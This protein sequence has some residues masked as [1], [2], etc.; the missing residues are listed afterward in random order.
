MFERL[1]L[2][3]IAPFCVLFLAVAGVGKATTITTTRAEVGQMAALWETDTISISALA[4]SQYPAYTSNWQYIF[5][6]SSISADG[7]IH[8]DMGVDSSGSGSSGNNIGESPII[9]EVINASSSQLSHLTSLSGHQAIFRGIFRFY[10]EHAGERHF[11]LHPTTQLQTWNGSAF[12]LDADYHSTVTNVADGATHASSTY[13]NLLNGSETMMATIAANNVNVTFSYPSPSV[14][15]IEYDGVVVS[16]LTSDA[17]SSYIVFRPNLVPNTTVRCR[18]IANTN[19]AAVA[20]GLGTGQPLTVNALTRTDMAAVADQISGLGPGDS[21]TFGRPVEFITLDLA[22]L[23]AIAVTLAPSGITSTQATLNGSVDPNGVTTTAYFQYGTSTNYGNTT[24]FQSVGSSTDAVG[25]SNQL[26]GL[27]MN[28]TYHYRTVATNSR[29]TAYGEDRT[30]TTSQT[31]VPTIT[32]Q[33]ASDVFQTTATLHGLV[34]PNGFTT[35]VQF[36]Y[37]K[38]TNYGTTTPIQSIGNGNGDVAVSANLTGLQQSQVYHFRV[39]ATNANGTRLGPDQTLNT[40]PRT[41]IVVTS[42]ATDVAMDSATL[43]GV[44][45]PGALSTTYHFE[46]GTGTTYGTSTPNQSAGSGSIDVAVST[47]LVA[48]LQPNTTYHFRLVATNSKGTAD[49]ADQV[50]TTIPLPPAATTSAATAV[51]NATA[52]LNGSVNPNGVAGTAQFEYGTTASYGNTTTAQSIS[53]SNNPTAVSQGIGGLTASTT[54]HFRVVA[55]T[56]G[57]TTFGADQM[58][59]TASSAPPT[60]STSPASVYGPSTVTFN[61]TV[62]ANAAPTTFYFEYGTTTVYGLTTP[63][64]QIGAPNAPMTFSA[65]VA[66]LAYDTVYH[67]RAVA[68]NSTGT[69]Y[70]SDQMF[71]TH[72]NPF[73]Q[74]T[75]YQFNDVGTSSGTSSAGDS[76]YF[77]VIFSNFT[78]VGVSANSNAS[79]RFSFTNQPLGATNGSDVFTGG[80]DLGKYYEFTVTPFSGWTIN[81]KTITFTLQRSGTGIRQYSVRS[82]VDNFATNL[83]ASINPANAD[84]MV[85]NTPHLN[86]FQVSDATTSAE[87]GTTITLDSRFYAIPGPITFR[88]YGYNAEGSVGTFSVDNVAIIGSSEGA[89][90][91]VVKPD[92]ASSITATTAALHT[93]VNPSNDETTVYFVYGPTTDY[94][95]VTPSVF[96]SGGTSDTAILQQIT[97]LKSYT[98]YHYKV[99]SVNSIGVTTGPDQTFTTASG[100]RDGDGVPDDWEVLNGLNPDDPSDALLDAD[101]DGFTNLQEYSAG[102][103]PQDPASRFQIISVNMDA[104]GYEIV[105]SSTPGKQYRVESADDLPSITWTA[106]ADNIQATA[107]TA[108][109]IDDSVVSVGRRFYRVVLIQ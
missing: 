44:V 18:L 22:N 26:S 27:A 32:T 83:S 64:E 66:G 56:T 49:G 85:V 1:L 50:F 103:N 14:N 65:A 78:A 42:A 72:P 88:L 39:V 17:V 7:D 96:I 105:F 10:T 99:V 62:N 104:D 46:Y 28:T 35:T 107:T 16:P 97:G 74:M 70:G 47:N 48:V 21:T 59:T 12:V 94:E 45:N 13:T 5:P 8:I 31:P 23:G 3:R 2:T 95:S 37:G 29:G 69:T 67:F 36:Q 98:N 73:E 86:I 75:S 53:A 24:A 63:A 101:G 25:L 58:F 43:N 84:L 20:A 100:D 40:P 81:L 51:S 91:P 34:N 61:A 80:I 15:Y 38:T 77:G 9:S 60:V 90:V 89:R 79:G 82:S 54:Y 33:P 109:V 108:T 106:V 68:V 92:V 30:F 55:T 93:V 4:D 102:T 19:A 52:T 71:R 11:E 57:G 76:T 87:N 41:P 6:H